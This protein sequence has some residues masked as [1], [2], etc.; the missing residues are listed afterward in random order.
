MTC[1]AVALGMPSDPIG[2]R[3]SHPTMVRLETTSGNRE[4]SL[5]QDT[6]AN[7]A[8]YRED[9]PDPDFGRRVHEGLSAA[10]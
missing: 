2:L 10:Q 1:A 8:D 3:S 4:M 7:P 6:L 5:T 9:F